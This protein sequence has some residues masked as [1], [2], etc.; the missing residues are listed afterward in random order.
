MS[1]ESS[2]R[3]Q[4][5]LGVSILLAS[6][7]FGLFFYFSRSDVKTVRVVGAA[8]EQTGSDV[9]KLRISLARSVGPQEIRTGY[10][11][12]GRDVSALTE[13]L[14]SAGF[15]ANEVQLNPASSFQNYSQQGMVTG[16]TVQQ[17]VV[18]TSRNV[19][20]LQALALRPDRLLALGVMLQ[21]IQIEYFSSNLDE[22]KKSL[23]AEATTDARKRAEEIVKGF[24]MT[25][26][27]IES[28]RAGVFQITEPYSTEVTDYGIYNTSTREKEITVTVA[29]TFVVE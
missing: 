12:I 27:S 29:A 4:A 1:G 20:T 7:V 6:F 24:G 22:I 26:R 11:E 14:F 19:D 18:V 15:A 2:I 5:V 28:A 23:L 10:R 17:S 25:I 21:S 9:A 3:G 16:Y 8:T 13:G